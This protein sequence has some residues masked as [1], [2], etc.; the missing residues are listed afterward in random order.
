MKPPLGRQKGNG[1]SDV[2]EAET[3]MAGNSRTAVDFFTWWTVVKFAF[4]TDLFTAGFTQGLAWAEETV[5]SR[6]M[7]RRRKKELSI[8]LVDMLTAYAQECLSWVAGN[9][10]D[11]AIGRYGRFS[12]MPDLPVYPDGEGWA[13]LPGSVGRS[14]G[15]AQ[16]SHGGQPAHRILRRYQQVSGS[17]RSGQ[18]LLCRRR[19]SGSQY[20]RAPSQ[21]L[22]VWPLSVCIRLPVRKRA[23]ETL[24]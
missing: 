7:T 19:A 22:Q 24:S 20:C 2:M 11:E 3:S 21:A 16:R 13:A 15:S 1:T 23:A 18:L 17:D 8:K 4:T 10:A 6:T 14:G 5:Q 12:E 9:E